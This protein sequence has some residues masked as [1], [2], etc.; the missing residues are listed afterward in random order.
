MVTTL[1]P[2]GHN[3]YELYF[4]RFRLSS[5]CP[6][7]SPL[8][9][10]HPPPFRA[11]KASACWHPAFQGVGCIHELPNWYKRKNNGGISSRNNR[12]IAHILRRLRWMTQ[13]RLANLQKT[14]RTWYTNPTALQQTLPE[15]AAGTTIFGKPISD[16]TNPILE[17][18]EEILYM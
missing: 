11:R 13:T 5:L 10:P 16:I 8:H 17:I 2:V 7:C 6:L 14:R 1:Y 3:V 4:F 15:M 9:N 12:Y 18:T